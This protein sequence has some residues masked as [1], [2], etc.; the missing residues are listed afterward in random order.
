M[1]VK[2]KRKFQRGGG[3][4]SSQTPLERKFRVD[5]GLKR[6]NLPWGGMDIFWN[7][8]ISKLVYSYVNR[9]SHLNIISYILH[10]VIHVFSYTVRS[11]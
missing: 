1:R 11:Y 4:G 3:G 8:T 2:K 7:C 10:I 6:K 9:S 5:G